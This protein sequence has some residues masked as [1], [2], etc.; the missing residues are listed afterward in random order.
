MCLAWRQ[1]S[2]FDACTVG[3]WFAA[4]EISTPPLCSLDAFLS[5]R[6][7]NGGCP[8][9][10]TIAKQVPVL[11]HARMLWMLG[12]AIWDDQFFPS[13]GV[14][15][16]VL[17]DINQRA[18]REQLVLSLGCQPLQVREL[19]MFTL[20]RRGR[21]S[22]FP[23]TQEKRPNGVTASR[24]LRDGVSAKIGMIRVG[25]FEDCCSDVLPTLHTTMDESSCVCG[26]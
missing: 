24:P 17:L 1:L 26:S 7:A 4:S 15:S 11:T 3:C 8:P 18:Q 20:F 13:A 19:M 6:L 16:F 2:A 5:D 10:E 9:V 25:R 21:Q 22:C 12:V 23:A 14:R